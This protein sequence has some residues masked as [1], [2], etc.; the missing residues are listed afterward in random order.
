MRSC[1]RRRAPMRQRRLRR[2]DDGLG[3]V[4]A[5]AN[6]TD[7]GLLAY[8]E[9]DHAFGVG[10]TT[11]CCA[12]TAFARSTLLQAS[13]A[14]PCLLLLRLLTQLRLFAMAMSLGG[15]FGSP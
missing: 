7:A 5:I 14:T 4:P 15:P 8:R 6:I 2:C 13:S 1:R 9:L 11:H 10:V 12:G 3:S